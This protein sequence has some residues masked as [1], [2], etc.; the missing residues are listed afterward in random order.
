M[1]HSRLFQSTVLFVSALFVFESLVFASVPGNTGNQDE[2]V[3]MRNVEQL[4]YTSNPKIGNKRFRDPLGGHTTVRVP[5]Q[6]T[7]VLGGTGQTGQSGQ[8]GEGVPV[9]GKIPLLGRLFRPRGE[10]KDEQ[11]LLILTQPALVKPQGG[12]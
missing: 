9:L 8:A 4:G 11:A 5:D 7:L 3:R 12:E 2:V 10:K 1:R 6:R